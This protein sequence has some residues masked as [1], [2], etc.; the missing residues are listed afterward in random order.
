MTVENER[1]KLS[2]KIKKYQWSYI[3]EKLAAIFGDDW[4]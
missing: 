1:G 2:Q 4:G 3:F